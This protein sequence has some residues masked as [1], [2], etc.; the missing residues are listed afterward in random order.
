MV[1]GVGGL[2]GLLRA[3][4]GQAPRG[5]VRRRRKPTAYCEILSTS[6]ASMVWRI[7]NQSPDLSRYGPP[8]KTGAT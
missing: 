4:A 5:G 8:A 7:C 3:A 6:I 1:S 2:L